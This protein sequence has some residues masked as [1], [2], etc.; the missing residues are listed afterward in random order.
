L[1][2]IEG[3]LEAIEIRFKK[4]S[5][6]YKAARY[7]VRQ[8]RKLPKDEQEELCQ[9][10]PIAKKSLQGLFTELRKMNLYPPQKISDKPYRPQAPERPQETLSH[11]PDDPMPPQPEYLTKEDFEAQFDILRKSINNLASLFNEEPSSNPGEDEEEENSGI[12]QPGEMILPGEMIQPGELFIQDGSST[13][14]SVYIKPKTR[15]YFDMSR[16]GAFHNYPG[17]REPGPL[18]NF[19]GSISD[20]FNII[21]DEFFIRNYNADIG[22][23]MRMSVK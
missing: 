18:A 22:L 11:I 20:F 9:E 4:D 13:R 3:K 17:T 5:K 21:V 23:T 1:S 8:N 15:M 10:I 16:Q 14:E 7:I 12:I 19:N 2:D 6:Q